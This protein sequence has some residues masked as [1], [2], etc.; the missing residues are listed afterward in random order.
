[1]HKENSPQFAFF[2]LYRSVSER[3]QKNDQHID[4][5]YR[6]NNF[7][8]LRNVQHSSG[9]RPLEGTALRGQLISTLLCFCQLGLL[10]R[11]CICGF[12]RTKRLFPEFSFVS[13]FFRS[14]K[15]SNPTL[16][17]F[18]T[19]KVISYEKIRKWKT[20]FQINYVNKNF[21]NFIQISTV[22]RI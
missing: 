3:K 4:Q 5:S 6:L 15:G 7:V 12:F 9:N 1:M 8:T 17:C 10:N 20:S 13:D 19:K 2:V 14:K 11:F 18:R 22:F 21:V 16:Y